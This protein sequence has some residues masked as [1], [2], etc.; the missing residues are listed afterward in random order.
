METKEGN[1]ITAVNAL[2]T[3]LSEELGEGEGF[4]ETFRAFRKS[5]TLYGCAIREI[6]TKFEVLNDELALTGSR[7]PI[8]NIY[9]RVKSPESIFGK[10]KRKGIP[11]TI[12]NMEMVLNDIAGVRV[13]CQYIDDIY[14]VAAMLGVN[15]LPYL[16]LSENTLQLKN[17]DLAVLLTY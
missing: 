9:S 5:M 7:N 8:K 17:A 14:T 2:R 6:R 13:V 12:E 16:F 15:D 1:L 10:M 4:V 11:F 3:S